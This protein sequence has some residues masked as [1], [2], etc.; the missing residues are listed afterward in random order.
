MKELASSH[1]EAFFGVDHYD[2]AIE[3]EQS[4]EPQVKNSNDIVITFTYTTEIAGNNLFPS[5]A[6][7]DFN[8]IYIYGLQF[9]QGKLYYGYSIFTVTHFNFLRISKQLGKIIISVTLKN[10]L[11]MM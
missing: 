8:F 1:I 6:L 7:Q 4:E 11:M 2:P 5:V 9:H 10:F 3:T